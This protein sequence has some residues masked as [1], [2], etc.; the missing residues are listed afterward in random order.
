MLSQYV[1]FLDVT[2]EDD[3]KVLAEYSAYDL[4]IELSPGT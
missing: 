2:S 1:E 4:A 3:A